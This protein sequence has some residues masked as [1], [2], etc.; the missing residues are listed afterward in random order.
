MNRE[1]REQQ[2][3]NRYPKH[4]PLEPKTKQNPQEKEEND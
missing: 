3:R 4:K 2:E 1:E